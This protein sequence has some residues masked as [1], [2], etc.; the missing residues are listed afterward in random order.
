MAWKWARSPCR[1]HTYNHNMSQLFM[2]YLLYFA[3]SDLAMPVQKHS[4]L[5]HA[6]LCYSL[7]SLCSLANVCAHSVRTCMC[8]RMCVLR[9]RTKHEIAG[10]LK[11]APND[12]LHYRP[13]SVLSKLRWSTNC[14]L[15]DTVRHSNGH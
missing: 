14:D 4:I 11:P 13:P 12:C 3:D 9:E 5:Q 6:G 10:H 1:T 8:I 7:L 15:Q 2:L